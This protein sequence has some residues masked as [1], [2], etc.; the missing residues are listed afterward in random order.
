M[1]GAMMVALFDYE[2]TARFGCFLRCSS[3][4]RSAAGEQRVCRV[5]CARAVVEI[6]GDHYPQGRTSERDGRRGRGVSA[7]RVQAV[8]SEW[9]WGE[10][11][12][13]G[14]RESCAGG[15]V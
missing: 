3:C 4:F 12:S 5:L 14:I 13:E 2:N 10:F 15:G 9:Q 8:G 6:G 1:E 11:R 7:A